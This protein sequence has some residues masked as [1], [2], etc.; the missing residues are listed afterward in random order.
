M[1]E[2]I[3]DLKKQLNV[4]EESMRHNMNKIINNPSYKNVVDRM[5]HDNM[6]DVIIAKLLEYM[7]VIRR[8]NKATRENDTFNMNGLNIRHDKLENELIELS[9]QFNYEF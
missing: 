6:C 4:V 9:E 8:L 2:L 3:N 5:I 1:E 7:S